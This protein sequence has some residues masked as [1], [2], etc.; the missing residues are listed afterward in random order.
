MKPQFS[1]LAELYEH[2]VTSF[3]K[4]TAAEFVGG[5]QSYT[6]AQF[7][8]CCDNISKRLSNFGIGAGDKVAILSENSPNWTAAFFAITAYGRIAIPMLPELSAG[9]VENIL[10][11]GGQG[12][13]HLQEA[14][15]ETERRGRE[16]PHAR[17]SHRRPEFHQG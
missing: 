8:D 4:R 10:T 3:P 9:E 14:A 11:L 13:L 12:H 5:A 17:H 16:A 15:A 2:S 6:Y 7:R 1:T